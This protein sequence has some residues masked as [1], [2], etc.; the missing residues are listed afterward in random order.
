MINV[1]AIAIDFIP[2]NIVI[3]V[4]EL[5]VKKSHESVWLYITQ[6]MHLIV[7]VNR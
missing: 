6:E 3:C 5:L 2:N 1:K 7:V 4:W